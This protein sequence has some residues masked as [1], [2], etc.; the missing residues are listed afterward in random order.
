MAVKVYGNP[1]THGDYDHS[2]GT[3]VDVREGHLIVQSGAS[4]STP[5]QIA[6][7][8]PGSWVRAEVTK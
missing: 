3:G 8:T 1:K 7:Y 2:E 5:R 4:V 6:V